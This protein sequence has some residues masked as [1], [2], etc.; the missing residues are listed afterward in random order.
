[1]PLNNSNVVT[2]QDLVLSILWHCKIQRNMQLETIMAREIVV[3]EILH[4]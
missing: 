2:G 3:V 1:M 4:V